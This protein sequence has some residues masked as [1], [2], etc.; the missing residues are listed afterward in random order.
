MEQSEDKEQ[1]NSWRWKKA[2][3]AGYLLKIGHLRHLQLR[4]RRCGGRQV[5]PFRKQSSC[6]CLVDRDLIVLSELQ[7]K[8]RSMI[9]IGWSQGRTI[10]ALL[11]FARKP[12]CQ[13]F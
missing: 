7:R 11:S 5:A 9:L 12:E 8:C 3:H 6:T 4:H 10:R 13:L 2:L 1:E